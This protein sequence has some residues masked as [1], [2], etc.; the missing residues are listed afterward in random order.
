MGELLREYHQPECGS[1]ALISCTSP[2]NPSYTVDELVHQLKISEA[3]LIIV[4]S[5]FL[6]TAQAAARIV[7][8]P[9]DHIIL[10]QDTPNNTNITLGQLIELGS[11]QGSNLTPKRLQPGEARSKL[12]LLSFSS[13]TTG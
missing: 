2:S 7:G 10:L 13:G 3:S 9:Q 4:H 6:H 8:I 12:A 5:Q 1:D 11:K